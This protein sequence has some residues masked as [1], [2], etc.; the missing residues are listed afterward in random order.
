MAIVDSLVAATVLLW[1]AVAAWLLFC[2]AVLVMA[3]L[4]AALASI[5]TALI[6]E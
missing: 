1:V 6:G 4:H 3:L 2:S 5:E